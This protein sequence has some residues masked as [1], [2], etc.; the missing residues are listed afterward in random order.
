MFV[1]SIGKESCKNLS[2]SDYNNTINAC[3]YYT[4]I[5]Y[6]NIIC[7]YIREINK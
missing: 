3:K 6:Y 7:D 1:N 4:I 5:I 2:K